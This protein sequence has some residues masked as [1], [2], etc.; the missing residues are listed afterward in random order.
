MF[1]VAGCKS[2]VTGSFELDSSWG[3]GTFTPDGCQSGEV[4]G[5]HGVDLYATS[6]PRRLRLVQEPTGEA[7]LVL[8]T[9]G[10][11][12]QALTDA[13]CTDFRIGVRRTGTRIN[14]VESYEGAA[15]FT[16]PQ[17]KGAVEFKRCA[18]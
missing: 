4:H 6:D 3:G 12:P 11:K 5:F 9:S 1:F 2:S 15:S 16:C 7:R 17:L 13:D 8:F 18:D 14:H 10:Q